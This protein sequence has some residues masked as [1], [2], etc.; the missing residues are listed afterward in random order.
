LTQI[1]GQPCEFQVAPAG[2][3]AEGVPA[4]E[5]PPLSNAAERGDLA[6][7]EALLTAGA[8]T[9]ARGE[10]HGSTA[11][12]LACAA[13]RLEC[14]QALAAAGCDVAASSSLYPQ[15][16]QGTTALIFA[17]HEGHAAVLAWLLGEGGSAG[18]LE[19]RNEDG[20]TAFLLACDRG[21]LECGQALAAAGCD[22]AAACNAGNTAL[23]AA[24]GKG[25]PAVLAWLIEEGGAA[26]ALETRDEDGDTAFLQ[27]CV[28][29]QLEC[30]QALAAAG[31]D[32]AAAT[33]AGDTALKY[34]AREGQET[35]LGW[36]LGQGEAAG[37]LEARDEYGN[38]AFL[39]ACAVGQLG[40]AQALAAAGCD[41]EATSSDGDTAL[42]LAAHEGHAPVLV[43]L[44]GEGGVA[45]TLE[46]R[47]EYGATAFL[48]ACAVGQLECAQ[49]LAAAGCDVAASNKGN[50]A[51]ICAARE[52]HKGVMA[53]LLGEGG[54]AGTLEA[55]DEEY[56]NTAFLLACAAGQ[57]GCAQALAAA[58]CDV[59][60]TSSGGD[61]ALMLAA[62][63]GQTA[64]V[65]WLL[66]EG[67]A[68]G[69]LEARDEDGATAFLDACG[70]GQ[71]ECA[72]A[73][74]AAGC[75][76]AAASCSGNTALILAA[77]KGHVAVLAWLLG[78]GGVAGT[79]E[80]RGE[81]GFTAFALACSEAQ[82]DCVELLAVAG[83]KMD[84][85]GGG[86]PRT[87]SRRRISGK[88]LPRRGHFVIMP[89]H[90]P[91]VWRIPMCAA[92]GSC[93]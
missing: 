14:A 1:L 71:L 39:D 67:K 49:T 45:G 6:E 9:E 84:E 91:F 7:L 38:T 72:Q 90:I 29:G 17:A 43:W 82:L 10:E 31:C 20:D 52:G 48:D 63:D 22:V 64:V 47:D 40:C 79:L 68:V 30:A 62:G 54:A 93:E 26:G 89:P 23:I 2:G 80:A 25:H 76:V 87:P 16:P 24:A 85:G 35:V 13:G 12:L 4:A 58:G 27:A 56:G 5:S 33:S 77:R 8:D 78:Q 53:W 11:F 92:N 88:A 69:T 65:A 42:M 21:Q 46:A 66:G 83:C 73:L 41:V 74:A 18:T 3:G 70:V 28:A 32:V 59:A 75:D 34:A 57:L 86:M 50:T 81:D 61:T 44:M 15:G 19:A 51:L 37:T 60:V 36:L 55:R